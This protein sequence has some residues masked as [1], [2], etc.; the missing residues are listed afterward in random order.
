MLQH[1]I[2]QPST[3]SNH[4]LPQR[5]VHLTPFSASPKSRARLG[6]F[7]LIVLSENRKRKGSSGTKETVYEED[8]YRI[9]RGSALSTEEIIKAAG[10][11]VPR[12]LK[13][14]LQQ[15]R[16][17]DKGVGA[18]ENVSPRTTHKILRIIAGK[19]SGKKLLSPADLSMRPMM[20]VV[21]GA[22]FDILQARVN[23]YTSLSAGRWLDL[24]SG[25]GS[26]G[27]EALSRGCA[28]AHFVEMDPWMTSKVLKPN[29][30]STEF[31]EQ[32]V[33]HIMKVEAFVRRA[34][35]PGCGLGAFDYISVTPPYEAVDYNNLMGQLATSSLLGKDTFM[36][37][38]YP[39]EVDILGSCGSLSKILNRRY[40]RTHLAIY[41]PE[42]AL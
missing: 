7:K 20:E 24:Y 35:K 30:E 27:I 42:W 32:S 37:V 22:V 34:S 28:L 40:G 31:S 16:K 11:Q 12:R 5:F 9:G 39:S 25:T 6:T 18:K 41:G 8:I 29:L 21:R 23:G 26:V 36:V 15:E 10:A 14:Q 13:Q 4:L 19:A 38:E 3:S 17:L 33:V 2:S 1:Y